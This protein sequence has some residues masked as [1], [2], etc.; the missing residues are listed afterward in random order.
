MWMKIFL[1]LLDHWK[2]KKLSKELG[3]NKAEA[4]GTLVLLWAWAFAKENKSGYIGDSNPE[5]I[6]AVCEWDGDPEALMKALKGTNRAPRFITPDGY[7]KNWKERSGAVFVK[8]E[9]HREEMAER[10]RLEKEAEK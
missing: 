9:K 5:V 3:I 7:L 6:A 4:I 1:S 2:R 10:R 8:K